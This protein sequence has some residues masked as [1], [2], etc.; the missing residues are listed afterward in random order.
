MVSKWKRKKK[1][2]DIGEKKLDKNK[3]YIGHQYGVK[4]NIIERNS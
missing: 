1:N 3:C 2:N 4:Q